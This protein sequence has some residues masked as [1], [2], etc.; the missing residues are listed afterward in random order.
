MAKVGD[1][2]LHGFDL[3]DDGAGRFGKDL[4][5]VFVGEFVGKAF[6]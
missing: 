3:V 4:L 2:L 5:V 6:L 1:D